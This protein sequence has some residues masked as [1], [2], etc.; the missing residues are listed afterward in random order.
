MKLF[1]ISDLHIGKQLHLHDLSEAQRSV[2][3][4]IVTAARR[5]RPDAILIA[6]DIYDRAAPSGEAFQI[7]DEF[8]NALGEIE[9]MI[10]VL[11][12]AG[13][14]D[15]SLRLGFA[16][17]FLEK[18]RIYISTVPPRR[19]EERL[20]KVV[21]EDQWGK[22]NFYLLP[23]IKPADARNLYRD[24]AAENV[25]GETGADADAGAAG[26]KSGIAE[27]DGIAETSAA[28]ETDG[29]AE[30]GGIP[31]AG[32]APEIRTYDD[33]VR[34]MLEREDIDFSQRNVLIAHQFFVSGETRPERRESELKYIS[35]GGI[36]S[37]EAGR[38]ERFDYAALGH[39]HTAQSIGK[40]HIR[41]SGSPLKYSVSESGDR[42]AITVVNLEEKGK[43]PEIGAIPL[44][45][46]P[47]VRVLKGTLEEVI[48]MS[49]DV[50]REDYV[51][52]VLTDSRPEFRPRERLNEFYER[53]VEVRLDS[54]KT[55][56][57]LEREF[58]G[59]G[60]GDPL[61][62][63]CEFY[64]EMNGQPISDEERS[65]VAKVIEKVSLKMQGGG[66]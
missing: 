61:T 10:P 26:E 13:N 15:S 1:H 27:A 62:L 60:E 33:A 64:Q 45:M 2:L 47:D 52:I 55:N 42:K 4:Q 51:S 24:R 11:I 63:F 48:A 19:E 46:K 59:E 14:H 66:R 65:V 3:A 6:G 38:I 35:V 49:D 28:V 29:I 39:I 53:I 17:S 16:S 58:S 37:V 50:V 34:V 5:E 23:F 56:A 40:S 31:E 22:V 57:L 20:K 44:V 32:G 36:D 7:F 41:Y 54:G 18:H 8:L 30:A 12:I 9:P 43:E 25:S 21:L